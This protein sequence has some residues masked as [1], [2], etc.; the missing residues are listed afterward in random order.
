MRCAELSQR[1]LWLA[2]GPDWFCL[3]W[4]MASMPETTAVSSSTA[5]TVNRESKTRAPVTDMATYL[6]P[7]A[8]QP[9]TK[10]VV[11]CF[12]I[13]FKIVT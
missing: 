11:T 13:Y 12:H 8:S 5:M 3:L 10:F 7:L 9:L 4:Q 2:S 1:L 6:S